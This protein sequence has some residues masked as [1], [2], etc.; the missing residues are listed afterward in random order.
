MN[1]FPYR[2]KAKMGKKQKPGPSKTIETSEEEKQ[3]PKDGEAQ[4]Q[5]IEDPESR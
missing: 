3:A 5:E 4:T 2:A 1:N